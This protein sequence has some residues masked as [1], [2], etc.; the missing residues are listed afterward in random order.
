MRPATPDADD[1]VVTAGDGRGDDDGGDGTTTNTITS[2]TTTSTTHLLLLRSFAASS[3]SVAT[4]TFLT[5]FIDVVKVRQQLAGASSQNMARTFMTILNE[6]GALALNKGV[7]PATAR[8]MLYGGLR[9][10]M[11]GPL[12]DALAGGSGSQGGSRD[13][14]LGVKIAAGVASGGI[15]AGVCNPTDIIKTR[16][17]ARGGSAAMGIGEAVREVVGNEAGGWRRL[18]NGT[19]PSMAR[20]ALLTAAQVRWFFVW[21]PGWLRFG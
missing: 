3:T 4:A 17:Q 13:A 10:G 20:A 18:W 7:V 9:I 2:A 5:N 21:V 14:G 11:Y 15:A 19:T 16:M 12:R 8:G 6:E 1:G